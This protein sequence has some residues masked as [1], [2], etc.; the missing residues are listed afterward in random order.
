MEVE[1]TRQQLCAALSISES[2]VRRHEL[3]GMPYTPVGKKQ[4]R[5]NLAEV[6]KWLREK[7]PCQ[8]GR[9][10]GAASTSASWSR[11]NAYTEACRKMK[12]RVMPS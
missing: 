2:T 1:L 4:K 3:E 10:R 9:T 7:Q 8:S 6:K 5:Y 12:L 11:A